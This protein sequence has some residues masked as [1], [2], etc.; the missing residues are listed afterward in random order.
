MTDKEK[1]EEVIRHL[2]I[3]SEEEKEDKYKSAAD[4]LNSL[5]IGEVE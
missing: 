5:V 2:Y 3:L 4:L 1:L